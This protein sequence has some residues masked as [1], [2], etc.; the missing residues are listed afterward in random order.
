MSNRP[1]HDP[2]DGKA[3]GGTD[4]A[5]KPDLRKGGGAYE[6]GLQAAL[7]VVISMG[8]GFWADDYFDSSPVGLF[9]GL[10][11]GFGAFTL[12]IWQLMKQGSAEQGSG[13]EPKSG[14]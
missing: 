7:S 1:P 4:S 6:G 14:D 9:V 11:V 5:S 3:E 2:G 12:R 8:I 10:A 13:R